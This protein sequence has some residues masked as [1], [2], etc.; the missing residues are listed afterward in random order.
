AE[1]GWRGRSG[2]AGRLAAAL[3]GW[4]PLRYEV[5]EE[6]SPGAD[7]ERYSVTPA[8]GVFRATTSA[9]GDVVVP[10]DRLRAALAGASGPAL[11]HEIDRLL[12][13]AWDE[14]LEPYRYAGAGASV[15]WLHQVV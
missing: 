9:N 4:T 5:T 13:S 15:T 7:G 1:S 12:G 3:R 2:T 8:L 10:E 14:E 11:S 6:P